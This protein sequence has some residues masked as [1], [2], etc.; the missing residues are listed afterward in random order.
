MFATTKVAKM[1]ILNPTSASIITTTL[2]LVNA[3]PNANTNT[4]INTNHMT[5][6]SENE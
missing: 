6:I 2:R 3:N 1:N 4:N 5:T